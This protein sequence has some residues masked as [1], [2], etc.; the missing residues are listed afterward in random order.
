[1]HRGYIKLWRKFQEHRFW[2]EPRKFSK[3]EA[4]L[5]LLLLANHKKSS[6]I[7]RGIT[8]DQPRGTVAVSMKGLAARWGWTR[9]RVDR[10]LKALKNDHQIDHQ[11]SNVTTLI[12]II[13]YDMYQGNDPAK[14]T[15][16]D[17]PNDPPNDPLLKNV[18]N[19][20]NVK[21]KEYP[22]GYSS[23]NCPHN[24]IIQAYHTEL[25]ELPKVRIWNE[26]HKKLLRARW[27][28]DPE[29]QNVDWWAKLFR[30]VS[31]SDFL[32]GRANDFQADLEWIVRPTNFAKIANGRYHKGKN[33]MSGIEQ[34]EKHYGIK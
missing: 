16:S 6:F 20:K 24:D 29:R 28:E 15:P 27:R 22:K 8:V 5:D 26:T 4:W 11:K 23:N 34:W 25:P 1:M 17:P 9:K 7:K 21:N 3:A 14:C 31:E 10:F 12:K 2:N 33:R 32:M 18:K 30:Y 13:N 19:E